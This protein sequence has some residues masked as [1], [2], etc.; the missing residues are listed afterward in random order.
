L[1]TAFLEALS[2]R[3]GTVPREVLAERLS[4][5]LLR[6]NGIVADLSRIFN[7]DGFEVVKT[8]YSSGTITLNLNL[9]KQQFGIEK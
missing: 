5:P 9:L 1:V 2:S 3:G 4:Q 8:D 6:I 7:V